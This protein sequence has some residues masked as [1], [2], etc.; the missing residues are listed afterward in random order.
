MRVK[1]Y[2]KEIA[3]VA[4]AVLL[5]GL[6]QP[7]GAKSRPNL[8]HYLSISFS[9][10][11]S[12]ILEDYPDLSTIGSWG[13]DF[14]IGYELQ[15]H[16]IGFWFA[17]SLTGLQYLSSNATSSVHLFDERIIDTQGKDAVMHYDIT[18]PLQENVRLLY[19][20]I[21]LMLGWFSYNGFY[22]GAGCRLAINLGLGST[23]S[24][25][26]RTYATYS[27]Y[28]DDFRDMPNHYYT[29]YTATNDNVQISSKVG[30]SVLCEVG[31]DALNLG[32]KARAKFHALKI[33]AFAEYGLLPIIGSTGT[34]KICTINPNNASE[35]IPGSFYNSNS[36]SGHH[37]NSLYV[38]VRI[39]YLYML[40][41]TRCPRCKYSVNSYRPRKR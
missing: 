22:C 13:A 32:R 15:D 40:Y 28:F 7:I 8:M 29:D 33:G 21:P 38:G 27:E 25:Q 20:S 14:H 10:G 24:L 17:G 39:T 31:Y 16:D 37:T 19:Y 5:T 30:F 26:Y 2:K 4:I 1:D 12:A 3:A 34:E 6:A 9:G 11:Y 18:S 41:A 35:V 23:S 36:S